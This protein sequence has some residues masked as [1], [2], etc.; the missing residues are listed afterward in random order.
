MIATGR[1]IPYLT[2]RYIMSSHEISSITFV[3]AVIH[4]KDLS[5]S[6]NPFKDKV[7][8][9][10]KGLINNKEEVLRSEFWWCD[11]I[12]ARTFEDRPIRGE[13]WGGTSSHSPPLGSSLY[14]INNFNS[15]NKIYDNGMIMYYAR[16]RSVIF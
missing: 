8:A 4:Q 11:L 15:F 1:M 12:M 3:Q 7:S 2:P 6:P 13:I 9:L 16:L 5:I 14:N 10:Y